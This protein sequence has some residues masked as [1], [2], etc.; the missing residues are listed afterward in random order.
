MDI[1]TKMIE[2]KKQELLEILRAVHVHGYDKDFDEMDYLDEEI[3]SMSVQTA[4]KKIIKSLQDAIKYGEEKKDDELYAEVMNILQIND[5]LEFR[6]KPPIERLH[7]IF[8]KGREVYDKIAKLT[9]SQE[10]EKK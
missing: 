4:L 6:I 3:P 10:E 8:R 1:K 2:E 5:N 9:T 7:R